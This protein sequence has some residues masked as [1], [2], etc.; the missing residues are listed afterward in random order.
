MTYESRVVG[1]LAVIFCLFVVLVSKDRLTPLHFFFWLGGVM[2][3]V[4][5]VM[6]LVDIADRTL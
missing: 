5:I 3:G 2:V 4:T 6:S 1:F